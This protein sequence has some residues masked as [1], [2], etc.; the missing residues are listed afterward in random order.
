MTGEGITIRRCRQDDA[1]A[2]LELWAQARSE[3]ATTADHLDD[4][5]RLIGDSPA[6]LLV[7]KRGDEIVGVLIAAWDGWRGNM[8]RLAVSDGHRRQ[9]IGLALTRAGEEYLRGC[10]ARRVTALVAFDDEVAGA[11]WESVG[12]PQDNE[13]GR[14]VRNL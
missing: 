6:A 13:I 4:V 2:V 14:R 10:G 1:Q 3:H 11:F 9:G 5:E 8:Y 7:A 12:Y